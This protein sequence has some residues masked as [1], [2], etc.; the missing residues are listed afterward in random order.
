MADEAAHLDHL[1]FQA[2]DSNSC[3]SEHRAAQGNESS[4]AQRAQKHR[5][6]RSRQREAGP[7]FHISDTWH[8]LSFLLLAFRPACAVTQWPLAHL[9]ALLGFRGVRQRAIPM[10]VSHL[11]SL[12]TASLHGDVCV[13]CIGKRTNRWVTSLVPPSQPRH[14]DAC[15]LQPQLKHQAKSGRAVSAHRTL[16]LTL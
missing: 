8:A 10:L 13:Y 2:R 1:I 3:P 14:W 12:R 9:P 5:G 6:R 4:S 11:I 7:H 15:F 16:S